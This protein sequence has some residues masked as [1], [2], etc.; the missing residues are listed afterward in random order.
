M[1]LLFDDRY[2]PLTTE[3]GALECDLDRSVAAY[4]S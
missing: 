4:L 3:I 1:Q 2:A